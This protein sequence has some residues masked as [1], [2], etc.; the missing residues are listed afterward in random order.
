VK[1]FADLTYFLTMCS[2]G[3]M[4]PGM[5]LQASLPQYTPLRLPFNNLSHEDVVFLKT[6]STT[7]L[8]DVAGKGRKARLT[9]PAGTSSMIAP[10]ATSTARPSVSWQPASSSTSTGH[11]PTIKKKPEAEM[12]EQYSVEL[13]VELSAKRRLSQMRRAFGRSKGEAAMESLHLRRIERAAAVKADIDERKGGPQFR[14]FEA[15]GVQP[16]NDD[17]VGELSEILTRALQLIEPD[18]YQRSWFKLYRFIDKDRNGFIEYHELV[19]CIR[20]KLLM[21]SAAVP[22]EAIQAFWLAVDANKSG[23]ICQEEFGRMM[24][25]AE[26]RKAKLAAAAEAEAAERG[27]ARPSHRGGEK[28]RRRPKNGGTLEEMRARERHLEAQQLAEFATRSALEEVRQNAARLNA[29]ARRLERQIARLGGVVPGAAPEP[30]DEPAVTPTSTRVG[31]GQSSS[32]PNLPPAGGGGAK[33]GAK[34]KKR[35]DVTFEASTVGTKVGI[36]TL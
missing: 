31:M 9:P 36:V 7:R 28:Q 3:I 17:Q 33:M 6:I 22:D 29:E 11:L 14:M 23:T 8:P 27:R 15:Q 32:V 26:K 18:P 10:A 21:D 12:L 25:L 24:R 5:Q 34:A 35:V 1:R 13:N 16:A 4:L 19:S 30:A 2:T 20:E